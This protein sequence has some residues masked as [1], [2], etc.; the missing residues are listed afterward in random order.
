MSDMMSSAAAESE[1]E[2]AQILGDPATSFWLRAAI[3]SSWQRDP[4]D[5]ERDA[6]VLASLLKRRVDETLARHPGN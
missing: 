6:L 3:A 1:G 4:L 2:L 5:A